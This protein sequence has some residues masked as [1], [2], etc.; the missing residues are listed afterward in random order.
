MSMIDLI[1]GCAPGQFPRG[2]CL[3]VSMLLLYFLYLFTLLFYLYKVHKVKNQV[4]KFYW[5]FS[6]YFLSG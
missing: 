4:N 5:S 6:L 1:I 3:A 2:M